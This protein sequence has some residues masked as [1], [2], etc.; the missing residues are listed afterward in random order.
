MSP[1]DIS[2]KASLA[3]RTTA[4]AIQRLMN[5][6]L[7]KKVP[8]LNDMRQPIYILNRDEL[9]AAFKSSSPSPLMRLIPALTEWKK[10]A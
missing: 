1:K 8:N 10:T 6:K 5:Q 4:F 9:R 7:L 3:P 2:E